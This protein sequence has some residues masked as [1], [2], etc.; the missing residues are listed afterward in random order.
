M[1]GGG[2]KAVLGQVAPTLA[3][4]LG[5]PLAGGV[6]KRL[7]GALLGDEKA[8]E[9]KV[10]DAIL[11]ADPAMLLKLKEL[12]QEY[13]KFVLDHEINLE[14]LASDDRASARSREVS[15]RDSITPRAL[16]GVIVAG[17]LA[18]VYMVLSGRVPGMRDPNTT[19]LI[20]TLIG[21]VSAK[22][23][24]VVGYYFGS[25]AGS[26]RKTELMGDRKP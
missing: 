4:A 8:S 25:S 10:A 2:W 23:D 9:G 3:S 7:A 12:D 19:V 1:K 24:Q 13:A 17:F 5:G 15:A 18:T 21:Y 11:K 26:D 14:K 20:G 22:A 16:A 6:V